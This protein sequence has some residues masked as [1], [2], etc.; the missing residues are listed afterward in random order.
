MSYELAVRLGCNINTLSC[1]QAPE[2]VSSTSYFLGSASDSA[3]KVYAIASSRGFAPVSITDSF[4]IRPV[5]II[6]KSEL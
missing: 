1:V 3:G 4:G 6:S 2:F 5:V